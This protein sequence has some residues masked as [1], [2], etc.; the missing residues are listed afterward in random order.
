VRTLV[1]RDLGRLGYEDGLTLQRDLCA[2]RARGEGDDTLLAVEHPEVVTVGR[3]AQRPSRDARAEA[4]LAIAAGVPVVEVERGGALTW[5][6]PGQ[7]VGYPIVRLD[8]GERDVHRMLREIEGA[9]A[10][11]LREATTLE[12]EPRREDTPTGLWV[13]GKK[14]AS[15]GIAVKRWVTLHGFA[16]NLENDLSRFALFRP[17]DL[18]PKVMTSVAALGAPVDRTK[19]LAAIHGSLARRLG[20]EPR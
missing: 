2:A 10:D 19:I 9:L 20:R 7:L 6:G 12:P 11:A 1:L 8:E 16:L 4:A 14:I 15:I 3:T 18:D 17:C 13:Q 5:H